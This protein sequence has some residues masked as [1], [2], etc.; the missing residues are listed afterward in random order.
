MSRNVLPALAVIVLATTSC[1]YWEAMSRR[2]GYGTNPDVAEAAKTDARPPTP[3]AVVSCWDDPSD[4]GR[5]AADRKEFEAAALPQLWKGIGG[6]GPARHERASGD[7]QTVCEDLQEKLIQNPG[8]RVGAAT[9]EWIGKQAPTDAKSVIFAYYSFPPKC[10]SQ[11]EVVRNSVGAIVATVDTH[12]KKCFENG[13]ATLRIVWTSLDGTVLG[14][15]QDNCENDGLKRC[16]AN[17]EKAGDE[18]SYLMS[19]LGPDQK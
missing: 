8:W 10:I 2:S 3:L 4:P 17:Y 13:L 5:D 18:V 11:D 9:R 12:Q 16:G 19:R 15:I 1:A 14:K 6:T 7:L